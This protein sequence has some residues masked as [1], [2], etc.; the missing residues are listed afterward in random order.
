MDDHLARG[1]RPHGDPE[2]DEQDTEGHRHGR[3]AERALRGQRSGEH[4][5]VAHLPE[6][7]PVRIERDR[8]GQDDGEEEEAAYEENTQTSLHEILTDIRRV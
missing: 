1:D 6:P 7:Q 5:L 4:V 3:G 8:R 2:V